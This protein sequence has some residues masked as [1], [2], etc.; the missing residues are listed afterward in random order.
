MTLLKLDF[1]GEMSSERMPFLGLFIDVGG[2][3]E[4]DVLVVQTECEGAVIWTGVALISIRNPST[5]V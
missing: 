4:G 2:Q 5:A 1:S 3:T